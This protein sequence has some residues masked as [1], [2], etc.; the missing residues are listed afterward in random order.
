[1]TKAKNYLVFWTGGD[2]K[3]FDPKYVA[4]LQRWQKDARHL[5]VFKATMQYAQADGKHPTDTA[6]AATYFNNV[7]I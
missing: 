2:K 1:M 4:L 3:A 7:R 6:Y 5:T